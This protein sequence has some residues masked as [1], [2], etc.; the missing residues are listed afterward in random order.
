MLGPLGPPLPSR[1]R[2]TGTRR[3]VIQQP[4]SLHRSPDGCPRTLCAAMTHPFHSADVDVD[5]DRAQQLIEEGEVQLVDVREPYEWDA[6]RIAGAR[7]IELERLAS[8]GGDAR[9]RAAGALLLPPRRP[10]GHGGQR[11]PARGLRRLLDGRRADGMGPTGAFRWSPTTAASRST[12]APSRPDRRRARARRAARRRG[13][14][15]VVRQGR[16]LRRAGARGGPA[17]RSPRASSS[18]SRPGSSS[19]S[20]TA[21]RPP[22]RSWI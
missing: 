12:D 3:Y 15:A 2:A 19:S 10:L 5:A 20:S 4:G 1:W 21:R 18:S 9:P 16:R 14:R 7:H 11:L 13:G 22:R 17:E 8:A 6:G